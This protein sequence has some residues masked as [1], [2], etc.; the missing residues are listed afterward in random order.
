MHVMQL[1]L[2]EERKLPGY[3]MAQD[4]TTTLFRAQTIVTAPFAYETLIVAYLLDCRGV[5]GLKEVLPAHI[6]SVGEITDV[7]QA[8]LFK[9]LPN[10]G[11]K[12]LINFA[13][14]DNRRAAT[15]LGRNHTKKT[16]AHRPAVHVRTLVVEEYA[17]V[18]RIRR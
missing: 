11:I 3:G 14:I 5:L 6:Q 16:D 8:L 10:R 15:L 7:H 12:P 18:F 1:H 4:G 9:L 13:A 2:V 17:F